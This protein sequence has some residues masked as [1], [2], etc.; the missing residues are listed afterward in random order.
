MNRLIEQKD[1]PESLWNGKEEMLYLPKDLISNWR[2]ILEQRGLLQQAIEETREGDIGGISEVDT[3]NHFSFRYNGSCA[4]FQLT[5]LD[6]KDNLREVSNAFV[7]SL[8]GYDVFIADIPSGTGAASLTLLSNIAQL[9]K[10]KVLP[11]LPLRVK[12]LAGE[13]SPTAIDIFQQSFSEIEPILKENEI[14]VEFKIQEWNIYDQD[15][16]SQLIREITL[17]SNDSSD[18]VMLLANFTGFLEKENNWKEVRT[19]FE[20]IFRHFSGSSTVAIW[21]E[22]KMNRVTQNFWPRTRD[23][24]IKTFKKL[25][26]SKEDLPIETSEAKYDHG[27]RNSA[28]RTGVAVVKFNT[29]RIENVK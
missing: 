21:L 3:H 7:K 14:M 18:K 11:T 27:L 22:P 2:N 8:A 20:E 23:W 19:Q 9:R 1:I 12:I 28:E 5:F 6:P 15:S 10:E 25:I 13:I 24:F 17:F 29:E 4:R 26:G 16:T